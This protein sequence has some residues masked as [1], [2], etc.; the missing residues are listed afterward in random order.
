MTVPAYLL[1]LKT[2]GMEAADQ[3]MAA[4]QIPQEAIAM[5]HLRPAHLAVHEVRAEGDTVRIEASTVVAMPSVLASTD[6][7]AC[8]AIMGEARVEYRARCTAV[9]YDAVDESY[10]LVLTL[11]MAPEPVVLGP[12]RRPL[13]WKPDEQ[14]RL[15]R[16][17]LAVQD[18]FQNIARAFGTGIMTADEASAAVKQ[19]TTAAKVP[20][21][22]LGPAKTKTRKIKID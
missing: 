7:V 9:S 6:Q 11:V 8:W 10:D 15:R 18:G 21:I 17:I 22:D 16:T 14:E 13:P 12:N 2:F 19:L 1:L 5:L 20:H 3:I 4:A